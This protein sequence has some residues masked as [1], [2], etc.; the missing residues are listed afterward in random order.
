[1]PSASTTPNDTSAGSDRSNP[2]RVESRTPSLLG[3]MW[4]G[5]PAKRST[6]GTSVFSCWAA[7]KVPRVASTSRANTT[8]T[9]RLDCT[10]ATLLN[11]G[12]QNAPDPA[13]ASSSIDPPAYT[14]PYDHS[15][16]AAL[17]RAGADVELLT[18]R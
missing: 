8:R 7:K 15:L 4:R 16:A 11:P 1:M 14:P 5:S 18:S 17:A 6:T 9:R 3:E 10:G 2:T 13:C 12:G